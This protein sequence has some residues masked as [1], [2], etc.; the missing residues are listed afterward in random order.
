MKK[1]SVFKH[2]KENLEI[3]VVFLLS[4]FLRLVNL[5][6]S[7]YQG[8]EIKAFYLPK[9]GQ[10]LRSFLIDQK[11]GPVQFLITYIIKFFDPLYENQFFTR[12]PFA[13]AGIFAVV[14]F[15]KF[16]K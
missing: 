4:S 6:Y 12:L 1:K 11:K 5:G 10:S 13:I 15:Y 3:I 8:D 7:D 9:S 16:V 14:F 2:I